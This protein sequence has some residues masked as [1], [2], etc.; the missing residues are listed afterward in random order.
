MKCVNIFSLYVWAF[1]YQNILPVHHWDTSV[2][3][4]NMSHLCA[5]KWSYFTRHGSEHEADQPPISWKARKQCHQVL[6]FSFF[7]FVDHYHIIRNVHLCAPHPTP[8]DGKQ[9]SFLRLE[10]FGCLLTPTD[11]S[12]NFT[13]FYLNLHI[14]LYKQFRSDEPSLANCFNVIL[15][16]GEDK[17][18]CVWGLALVKACVVYWWI[19]CMTL[20]YF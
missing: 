18:C 13:A 5:C 7:T 19:M 15:D 4:L 14:Y 11:C 2:F 17:S 16:E 9:T 1:F 8:Q 20:D 3:Y 10:L 6:F 12:F